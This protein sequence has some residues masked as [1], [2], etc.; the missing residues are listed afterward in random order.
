MTA[1]IVW[2]FTLL[3]FI[4]IVLINKHENSWS[5]FWVYIWLGD[6]VIGAFAFLIFFN[7]LTL[8]PYFS[9]G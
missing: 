9:P 7:N 2:L 4:A 1:V 6:I 3:S 5:D 8:T